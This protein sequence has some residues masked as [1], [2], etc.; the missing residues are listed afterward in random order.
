MTAGDKAW[1]HQLREAVRAFMATIQPNNAGILVNNIEDFMPEKY[2]AAFDE[3]INKLGSV[4]AVADVWVI[5]SGEKQKWWGPKELGYV[6]ELAHAGV[7]TRRQAEA[8]IMRPAIDRRPNEAFMIVD[9]RYREEG[10]GRVQVNPGDS[11]QQ[12]VTVDGEQY[13]KQGNGL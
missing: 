9:A 1:S 12:F 8:I 13:R 7:Y 11:L 2:R 10:R 6:D 3:L 4:S 5:W